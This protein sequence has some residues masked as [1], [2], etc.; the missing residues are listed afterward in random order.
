MSRLK[1]REAERRKGGEAEGRLEFPLTF[2]PFSLSAF[3]PY[4]P[5]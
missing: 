4:L 1:G 3:P 2:P 5:L